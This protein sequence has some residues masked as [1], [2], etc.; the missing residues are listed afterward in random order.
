MNPL[1]LKAM[2][3]TVER[4]LT[5]VQRW[6]DKHKNHTD[7]RV[8]HLRAGLWQASDS[9]KKMLEGEFNSGYKQEMIP[10]EDDWGKASSAGDHYAVTLLRNEPV[11]LAT[12]D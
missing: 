3:R 8:D 7:Y 1:L 12:A 11:P 9:M 2:R 4:M 10:D 6:E 5:I